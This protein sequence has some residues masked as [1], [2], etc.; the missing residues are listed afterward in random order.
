MAKRFQQ[1]WEPLAPAARRL[2]L[3]RLQAVTLASIIEREAK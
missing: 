2:G 3:S 1:A